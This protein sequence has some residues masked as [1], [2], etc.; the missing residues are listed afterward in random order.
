MITGS[1][2]C[3]T[4]LLLSGGLDSSILLWH[5]LREGHE[6]QPFYVRS[7][8]AWESAELGAV[9]RLLH[10]VSGRSVRRLVV[11]DLP[12]SDL[13]GDHWS[14]TGRGVPDEASPDEA[15]FLPGRNALLVI[16][17]AL[18]CQM[19]SITRLVLAPLAS[20]PFSDA[21][22]EFFSALASALNHGSPSQV[23]IMRPFAVLDK[24]AVMRF[25]EGLPLELTF[26]CIAPVGRL[27]CGRCNKCAERQAAFRLIA[28]A[29]PTDYASPPVAAAQIEPARH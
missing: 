28:A 23:Q 20:N 13:Y 22:D 5:L 14:I 17:A 10:F 8:L 11:L 25:G 7:Q 21:T 27:H 29:D 16:K 3:S 4:G 12:L 26:S 9:K 2:P 24:A 19:R 15:V 1:K 18:W 6:V